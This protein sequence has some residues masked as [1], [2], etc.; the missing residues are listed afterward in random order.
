[1]GNFG[2]YRIYNI[3]REWTNIHEC[4]I[5]LKP[6][7]LDESRFNLS[8][9]RNWRSFFFGNLRFKSGLLALRLHL[10]IIIRSLGYDVGQSY[11]HARPNSTKL[12]TRPIATHPR[13]SIRPRTIRYSNHNTSWWSLEWRLL[14]YFRSYSRWECFINRGRFNS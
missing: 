9:N 7:R 5:S 11:C 14:I 2:K 8:W 10:V 13:I 12:Y 6:I 1:M 4:L 3:N